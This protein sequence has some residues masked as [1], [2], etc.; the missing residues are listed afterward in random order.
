MAYDYVGQDMTT[1]EGNM[2]RM[3]LGVAATLALL[4]A[5]SMAPS[6]ADAMTLSTPAGIAAATS[7][8]SLAETVAYVCHRAWRCGAYGCGWRR[9]CYYTAP[10]YRYRHWRY[11]HYRRW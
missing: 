8:N 1:M 5:V 6:R 11:R 2:R 7:G 9:A 3:T 4:A 10:R